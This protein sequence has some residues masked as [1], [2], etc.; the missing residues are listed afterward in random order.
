MYA[1]SLDLSGNSLHGPLASRFQTM[2]NLRDLD[3]ND[4]RFNSTLEEILDCGDCTS[5]L[6]TFESTQ[7]PLTG[8]IPDRLF[9]FLQLSTFSVAKSKLT[10]TIPSD[11]GR[12]TLLKTLYLYENFY[13]SETNRLPSEIGKLDLLERLSVSNSV[14]GGT[15]PEEFANLS[16]L[17]TLGIGRTSQTGSIPE[18]MC[19]IAG[20]ENILHSPGMNCS[21][22]GD[23]CELTIL[24]PDSGS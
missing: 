10:G 9:D 15:V 11:I 23:V 20:L 4:N 18:G 13:F 6:T 7:N 24:T 14:V 22:S 19:E 5:T 3:L 17:Q 16:S 8:S 2:S 1:E 12:L 21:C